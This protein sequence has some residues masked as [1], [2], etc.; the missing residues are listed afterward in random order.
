MSAKIQN[1]IPLS[2]IHMGFTTSRKQ[3]LL[4]I[5]LSL[6][7]MNEVQYFKDSFPIHSSLI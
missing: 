5:S 7:K 2:V 3:I 1:L 4:I 6:S